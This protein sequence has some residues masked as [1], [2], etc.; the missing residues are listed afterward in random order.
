MGRKAVPGA[1]VAATRTFFALALIWLA[2]AASGA[3]LP[4]DRSDVLYHSYSGGGLDVHGPSI[5]VRK[6]FKDSVSV[7]GNYYVDLI[8]SASIDVVTSG[9]SP[10]QERRDEQSIGVDYLHGKTFLGLSYLK[11]DED[12]YAANA[13]RFGI[14]QDFFGDLTTLAISY[15]YGWDEVRRNGE[16]NYQRQQNS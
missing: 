1:A 6:G 3:I 13:A 5:L 15:A 10:Y 16:S 14:S 12:D 8:T 11:S 4:E 2:G 9:A 7:W